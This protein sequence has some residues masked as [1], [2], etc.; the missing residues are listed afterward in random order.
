MGKVKYWV[1]KTLERLE[2]VALYKSNAEEAL[3]WYLDS[4]CQEGLAKYYIYSRDYNN[5]KYWWQWK[6]DPWRDLLWR[7]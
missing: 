3:A 4:P 2:L 7:K 6:L 1:D 5:I